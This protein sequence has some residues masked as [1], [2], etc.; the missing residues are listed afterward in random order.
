MSYRSNLCM[1]WGLVNFLA[2]A[3]FITVGI[4]SFNAINSPDPYQQWQTQNYNQ[5][6]DQNYQEYYEQQL[7]MWNQYYQ[8]GEGD[9]EEYMKWQMMQPKE[10]VLSTRSMIFTMVWI[11]AISIFLG[12]LGFFVLSRVFLKQVNNN[13]K[14]SF[15]L[16]VG[17][18]FIFAN[19]LFV[20]ANLF[21]MLK[22]DAGMS[23]TM[24]AMM[25]GMGYMGQGQPPIQKVSHVFSTLCYVLSIFYVFFGIMAYT[26]KEIVIEE[27]EREHQAAKEEIEISHSYSVAIAPNISKCSS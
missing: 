15:G 12:A 1:G 21:A 22:V 10:A 16:F 8:G 26:S 9:V 27:M 5:G 11:G 6:Y 14:L 25:K 18:I 2:L 3:G 17:A 7:E 19:V 23:G 4:Y 20:C 13:M 24:Y